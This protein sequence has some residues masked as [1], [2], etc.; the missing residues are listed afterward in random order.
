MNIC[1]LMDA[2]ITGK[3]PKRFKSVAALSDYTLDN[4]K[5]YPRDNVYAGSLLTFLLRE[6]LNPPQEPEQ[7]SRTTF[8]RL[9]QRNDA[10]QHPAE[11]VARERVPLVVVGTEQ[12][13]PPDEQSVE[14]PIP[15]GPWIWMPKDGS[16]TRREWLIPIIQCILDNMKR[17]EMSA[18]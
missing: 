11:N 3:P 2:P 7:V 16:V 4:R 5:I 10:Q 15:H 6:I 13:E 18:L 8:R 17:E 14:N 12:V 9:P 1:D